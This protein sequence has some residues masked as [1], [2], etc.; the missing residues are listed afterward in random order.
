MSSLHGQLTPRG[1]RRTTTLHRIRHVMTRNLAQGRY[2][3]GSDPKQ[4]WTLSKFPPRTIG[5]SYD[6]IKELRTYATSKDQLFTQLPPYDCQ[7]IESY[8]FP[9]ET[10]LNEALFLQ[11]I[12]HAAGM[13][14]LTQHSSSHTSNR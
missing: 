10:I 6:P 11:K 7:S 13:S 5:V 3:D 8:T 12:T 9:P 4:L 14:S 1:S 2:P